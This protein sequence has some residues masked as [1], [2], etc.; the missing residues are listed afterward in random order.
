[1]FI[2]S[3]SKFDYPHIKLKLP[4][5]HDFKFWLCFRASP[6]KFDCPHIKSNL[7]IYQVSTTPI[8]L[9]LRLTCTSLTKKFKIWDRQ[10]E[11]DVTKSRKQEI[12]YTRQIFKTQN[13]AHN[14]KNLWVCIVNLWPCAWTTICKPWIF[15]MSWAL[16]ISCVTN[17]EHFM[18]AALEDVVTHKSMIHL[19]PWIDVQAQCL[20]KIKSFNFWSK[21]H[22]QNL[23]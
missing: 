17:F 6:S 4:M 12:I 3:P 10:Q 23:S 13:N 22:L 20:L 18:H 9:Y 19:K 2:V 7:P 11:I 16:N 15:H 14:E 8:F 21:W 1:M 5:Y